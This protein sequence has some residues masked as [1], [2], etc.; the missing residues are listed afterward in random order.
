MYFLI[1]NPTAPV[2]Q[3]IHTPL[4]MRSLDRVLTDSCLLSWN[5]LYIFTSRN[6]PSF[7]SISQS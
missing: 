1:V 3:G 4:K 7:Y 2:A 5:T 6:F